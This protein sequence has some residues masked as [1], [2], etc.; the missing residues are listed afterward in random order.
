MKTIKP[1][2]NHTTLIYFLTGKLSFNLARIK[3]HDKK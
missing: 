3:L 2:L 1:T